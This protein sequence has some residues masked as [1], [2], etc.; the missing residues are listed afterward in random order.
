METERVCVFLVV[1]DI[2]RMGGSKSKM[3][4]MFVLLLIILEGGWSKGCLEL[5]RFGLLQLKH[6]FNSPYR[7]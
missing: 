5:Q 2:A 3:V 7:L 6:F 4:T 1:K